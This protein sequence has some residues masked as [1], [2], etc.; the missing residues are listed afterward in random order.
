MA[1]EEQSA[2]DR[3]PECNATSI[4][5]DY[6]RGERICNSCGLVISERLIDEGPEWRA[7]T[8]DEVG[9][10]SRVGSPTSLAVHDKGLSTII[11]W[12]DKDAFGRKLSPNRRALVYRLRKWQVRMRV[13]CSVA[14]NLVQAMNELDRLASQ[15]SLSR[16]VKEV[17]ASIYRKSVEKKLIRGRSIE[18]I[19]AASVYAACRLTKAPRTLD[20]VATHCRVS[21]KELGRCYRL[22]CREVDIAVPAVSPVDFI[23]RLGSELNLSGRTIKR[24]V[25]ILEQAVSFGI[26]AGKD[27]TGLAAASIYVAAISEGERRTQR[28][29]ADVARVTEVTVRNRYK[30]LLRGLVRPNK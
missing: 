20:E 16:T 2:D 5:L 6:A 18:A 7:F 11:D 14:R 24:A 13:Q 19:V 25:S 22:L 26:A 1:N 10:R 3:C 29:I 21:K 4:I 9:R 30:E 15:L 12:R 27:P 17:A 28:E 23:P 8:V